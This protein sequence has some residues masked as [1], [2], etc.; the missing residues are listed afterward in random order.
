[1]RSSAL[2]RSAP[3]LAS[4]GGAPARLAALLSR[5]PHLV[6]GLKAART[7]DPPDWLLNAGAIRDAVWDALH[8]RPPALPRDVDLGFFDARDLSAARE[9]AVERALRAARPRRP[10][11]LRVPPQPD[12]GPRR[13]VR[14]PR[15]REGPARALAVHALRPRRIRDDRPLRPHEWRG[16]GTLAGP[17]SSAAPTRRLSGARAAFS[18]RTWRFS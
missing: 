18:Y 11:R 17:V 3:V 13:A 15:R 4:E 8:D 1:V 7:V 6:V 5:A 14:A 2:G 12:A 16:R 9:A 10:A